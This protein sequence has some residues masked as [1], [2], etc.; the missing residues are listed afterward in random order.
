MHLGVWGK[1]S[2][3]K[4]S[5]WG[6]VQGM[7]NGG[8]E[9]QTKSLNCSETSRASLNWG[10]LMLVLSVL[11]YIKVIHCLGVNQAWYSPGEF[12]EKRSKPKALDWWTGMNLWSDRSL[13]LNH[14]PDSSVRL[15]YSSLLLGYLA[16]CIYQWDIHLTSLYQRANHLTTCTTEPTIVTVSTN[17]TYIV[18]VSI[19]APSIGPD[20]SFSLVTHGRGWI[21]SGPVS[22]QGHLHARS[23]TQI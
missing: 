2:I 9:W 17:D 13:T 8:N 11:R 5:G 10:K 18:P 16:C 3:I 21:P 1:V 6:W 4:C 19:T 12:Q 7:K 20:R 22:P 23:C 14:S 15:G